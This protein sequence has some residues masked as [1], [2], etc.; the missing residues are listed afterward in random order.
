MS[1]KLSRLSELARADRARQFSSIAHFLTVDGVTYREYAVDA[2][3]GIAQR[4]E[5][6]RSKQ[7]R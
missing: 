2:P 1:T 5:R 3:L 7:Y 6:L 4:H